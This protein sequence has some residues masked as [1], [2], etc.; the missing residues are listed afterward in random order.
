MSISSSSSVSMGSA[1]GVR[2]V[3]ARGSPR[4]SSRGSSEF[5]N[6]LFGGCTLN[7]VMSSPAVTGMFWDTKP[8]FLTGTV[9]FIIILFLG[10]MFLIPEAVSVT[11]MAVVTGPLVAIE[12]VFLPC[13]ISNTNTGTHCCVLVPGMPEW[14]AVVREEA[15]VREGAEVRAGGEDRAGM[16]VDVGSE[17][18]AGTVVR[19][20]VETGVETDVGAVVTVVPLPVGTSFVIF[21][22]VYVV[23][24]LVDLR[25]RILSMID[26]FIGGKVLQG[27]K[28]RKQLYS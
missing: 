2:G 23:F 19:V 10:A 13:E 26:G 18:R 12:G 22:L 25:I 20:V 14:D 17:V 21:S 3:V 27:K 5:I 28:Q 9:L 6:W 11:G 15:E 4:G 7:S 8:A 1:V 16:E 24:L